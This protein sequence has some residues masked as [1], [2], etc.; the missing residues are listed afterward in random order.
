MSDAQNFSA[1]LDTISDNGIAAAIAGLQSGR[2]ADMYHTFTGNDQ[3]TMLQVFAAMSDSQP[4][5]DNLN[6]PI[7]L[8]NVIVQRVELAN[9]QTGEIGSQ[10][11]IT[12]V[13]TE[14][15]AYNVTSPVVLRDVRTL[16]ALVGQPATWKAPITVQFQ[17]LGTGTRKFITM[18]PV[19]SFKK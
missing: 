3:D 15:K 19:V 7:T 1:E 13:D 8:A 16:F 10:P 14:N 4:V 5:A 2:D 18:K 17:R 11:R 12:F 6:K 9:E